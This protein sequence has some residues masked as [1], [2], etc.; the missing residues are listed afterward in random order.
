MYRMKNK[1]DKTMK[2][3]QQEI[4]QLK[5]FL[6]RLEPD[7]YLDMIFKG[8]LEYVERDIRNDIAYNLVDTIKKLDDNWSECKVELG[9]VDADRTKVIEENFD[10]KK[11]LYDTEVEKGQIESALADAENELE[12][13]KQEVVRLKARLYDILSEWL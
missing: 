5:R 2:S 9:R 4:D 6:G 12:A 10:V 8:V 1:G 3:K 11:D 13:E 7:G